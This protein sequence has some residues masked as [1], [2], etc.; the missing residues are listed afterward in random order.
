MATH[1]RHIKTIRFLHPQESCRCTKPCVQSSRSR[2]QQ[3][4]VHPSRAHSPPCRRG[5]AARDAAANVRPPVVADLPACGRISH[6]GAASMPKHFCHHLHRRVVVAGR[7]SG[8]RAATQSRRADELG[9]CRAPPPHPRRR[10]RRAER[11]AP[12][13]LGRVGSRPTRR[14]RPASRLLNVT[15]IHEFE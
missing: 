9:A 4:R 13:L 11:P 6:E 3:Q 2:A 10:L 15:T 14:A 8:A 7:P 12:R 1:A 5:A